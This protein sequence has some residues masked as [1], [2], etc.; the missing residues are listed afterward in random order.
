MPR[1]R[2]SRLGGQVYV[3][4]DSFVAQDENGMD[5]Q[6]HQNRTRVYEGDPILEKAPHLFDLIEDADE[7]VA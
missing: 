3:P 5:K 1:T 7:E 6:Y 2:R 4:N